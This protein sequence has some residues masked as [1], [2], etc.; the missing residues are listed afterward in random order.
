MLLVPIVVIV[1]VLVLV[2]VVV[3]SYNRLNR[4][5]QGVAEAWSQIDVLLDRRHRLIG[6]LVATAAGYAS[7]E[8]STTEAVLAARAS[9]EAVRPAAARGSAETLLDNQVAG[10]VAR[11]EAYPDL[12]ASEVFGRLQRELVAT[13]D[14]LSASRRYYNGRVRL[15]HNHRESFPSNLLAGPLKFNPAEYFQVDREEAAVPG[16]AGNTGK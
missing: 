10:L 7:F 14:E 8:R 13:E 1:A 2:E 5:R 12:R 4:A 3:I 6:D 16:V 9:A 15:Y 11:A